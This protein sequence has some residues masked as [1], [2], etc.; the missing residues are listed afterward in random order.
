MDTLYGFHLSSSSNLMLSE[1]PAI[2]TTELGAKKKKKNTINRY[3][4]SSVY[5]KSN[6]DQAAYDTIPIGIIYS[7]NVEKFLGT[8]GVRRNGT[9]SSHIHGR[10]HDKFNEWIP[11]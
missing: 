5:K 11:P 10:S 7:I 4:N 1:K 3:I 8:P 9:P 2:E 6:Y